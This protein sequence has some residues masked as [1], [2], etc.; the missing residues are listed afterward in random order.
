MLAIYFF[1]AMAA[2]FVGSFWIERLYK[3]PNAPLSFSE[4]I[5][6]RSRFRKI[7]LTIF[8]FAAIVYFVEVKNLQA[9]ISAYAL[10]AIF[11]LS[12]VTMTDFE[13]YVIFNKMLLPFALA[14]L[15]FIIFLELPLVNHILA[16]IFGGGIFFILMLLSKNGL[17]GGDV[18]LIFVLGLWFGVNGLIF[19]ILF[20][21]ILA[22][23]F[24]IIFLVTKIKNRQ[25]VFAYGP[26]FCISAIGYLIF[27]VQIF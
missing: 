19:V 16:A 7:L 6:S 26:Y 9:I 27:M 23:V 21:A 18:K 22:G 10:T 12:L 15:P 5:Q 14:S 1:V 13:Q 17:G 8:F 11:F 24:A 20:G 4:K 25:D 2:A 3:M